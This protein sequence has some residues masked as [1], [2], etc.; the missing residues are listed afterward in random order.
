MFFGVEHTDPQATFAA[1]KFADG[2]LWR[3]AQKAIGYPKDVDNAFIWQNEAGVQSSLF[4]IMGLPKIDN[5]S[6]A[7]VLGREITQS[8]DLGY[9]QTSFEDDVTAIRGTMER[10]Q[11][12][13]FNA[14]ILRLN[15]DTAMAYQRRYACI[16]P[17]GENPLDAVYYV[18]RVANL[19]GITLQ[20][21]H[22]I[23][24]FFEGVEDQ[25]PYSTAMNPQRAYDTACVILQ[26]ANKFGTEVYFD[27]EL[28]KAGLVT[29]NP[30]KGE[31]YKIA[32]LKDFEGLK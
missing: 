14:N 24:R 7:K 31:D 32:P 19:L 26:E 18:P 9:V 30:K 5:A 13:H 21:F 15:P 22:P 16:R 2:D 10:C 20:E 28:A 11:P 3:R 4:L 23:Y 27:F 6:W 8:K 25:Q 17:S 1:D 29:G 12:Y